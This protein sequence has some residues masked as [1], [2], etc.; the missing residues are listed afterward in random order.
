M[1]SEHKRIAKNTLY[2]YLRMILVLGVSLYSS[3][4]L[5]QSLGVVDLGIYNL[6]GGIIVSLSFLN[7]SLAGASSRFITYAL[8]EGIVE[9]V[10][11]Y[12]ATL[13]FLHLALA[14]LLLV[15][16]Q[17]FAHYLVYSVL[18]IPVDRADTAFWLLQCSAISAAV[19]IIAV[20]DN[21]LIMAHERMDIYAY[22]AIGEAMLK[23]LSVCLL[24]YLEA[25]RLLYFGIFTLISQI[26]IRLAYLIVCRSKFKQE[27]AK[28]R[29]DKAIGKEVLGFVGWNASGSLSVIGY[30][31]GINILLNLFFGPV[32]NAARGFA[33]QIQAA[34]ENIILG[35]QTAVRPQI[36]KQ[37]ALG[38]KEEVYKLVLI[39]SKY[40]FF[41]TLLLVAPLFTSIEAI[42]RL[43]LGEVPPYT[44]GMSVMFLCV[45]LAPPYGNTC[46]GKHS[47][48]PDLRRGHTSA[49]HSNCVS[50]TQ[51]HQ[52]IPLS[53]HR[54]IST[55]GV[56]S[57]ARTYIYSSNP[58][59]TFYT[60][61][62]ILSFPNRRGI[63]GLV[64]TGL[65]TQRIYY[66]ARFGSYWTSES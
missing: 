45:E 47:K 2:L 66:R 25:D 18:D 61:L 43:W 51:V 30:T 37:Y 54:S 40:G 21:S 26:I 22:I 19:S 32:A 5:L 6:I 33:V 57:P 55:S 11:A 38:N 53:S 56:C 41:L 36:I 3:R 59:G 63:H 39:S 58:D 8:G 64:Y 15:V 44:V 65:C 46:Y 31:Q 34:V 17:L 62:S 10:R 52:H 49:C 29:Y 60:M 28:P 9:K 27:R 14:I 42:L 7:S 1:A 50:F 23:L 4:V 20:P 16:T 12:Y 13:Q 35:F 24:S 48:I